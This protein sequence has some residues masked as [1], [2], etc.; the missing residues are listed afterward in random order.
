MLSRAHQDS[1]GPARAITWPCAL[2]SPR[3]AR[4]NQ[5]IFLKNHEIGQQE[6]GRGPLPR[7]K[8]RLSEAGTGGGGLPYLESANPLTIFAEFMANLAHQLPLTDLL[9]VGRLDLILH[10]VFYVGVRQ[11]GVLSLGEVATSS[12]TASEMD[13]V[14]DLRE[15]MKFLVPVLFRVRRQRSERENSVKRQATE[16]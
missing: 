16:R 5:S 1:L 15:S 11:D 12:V 3:L 14:L 6:Q 13:D 2:A 10:Q 4:P 7:P 8:G 9:V